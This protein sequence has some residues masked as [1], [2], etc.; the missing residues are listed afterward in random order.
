VNSTFEAGSSLGR[1]ATKGAPRAF[2][3]ARA[4]ANVAARSSGSLPAVIKT[5]ARN[6]LYTTT[7]VPSSLSTHLMIPMTRPTRPGPAAGLV[8]HCWPEA[9]DSSRAYLQSHAC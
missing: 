7:Y 5:A 1:I 3:P 8:L 6:V 2:Q 9:R 4:L